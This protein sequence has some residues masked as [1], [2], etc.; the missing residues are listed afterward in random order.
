MGSHFDQLK[1]W[2][3]DL[4]LIAKQGPFGA[5]TFHGLK[6]DAMS[7]GM[8]KTG[9]RR[10]DL[11]NGMWYLNEWMLMV[12]WRAAEPVRT[13]ALLTNLENRYATSSTAKAA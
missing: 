12:K 13:K 3:D 4:G 9:V 1:M 6:K 2:K 8:Q 5:V 10:G 7:S 11:V